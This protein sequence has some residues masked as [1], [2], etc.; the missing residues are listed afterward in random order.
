MI[1]LRNLI[2]IW[3]DDERFID[4][5]YLKKILFCKG[6]DVIENHYLTPIY[7]KTRLKIITGMLVNM[8]YWVSRLGSGPRW[9]SFF[10][11]T[12]KKK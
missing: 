12:A 5:A 1:L 3:T 6:F 7:N 8:M 10:I 11:M 9:Q 2:G 4:P